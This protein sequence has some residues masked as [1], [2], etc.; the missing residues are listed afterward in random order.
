MHDIIAFVM[1]TSKD[2][3]ARYN[4]E[5][6]QRSTIAVASPNAVP[7]A[8]A[9]AEAARGKAPLMLQR[10]RWT[11]PPLLL[12]SLL[13]LLVC[14]L[15]CCPCC[16]RRRCCRCYRGFSPLLL[17]LRR[18]PRPW[19]LASL[20]PSRL[21]SLW[22]LVVP[23]AHRCCCGCSFLRLLRCF[24][25]RCFFSLL[26]TQSVIA[27]APLALAEAPIAPC[28][29]GPVVSRL[30]RYRRRTVEALPYRDFHGTVCNINEVNN[31]TGLSG[32]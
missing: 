30:P 19:L 13:L 2:V 31:K 23:F 20:L 4:S 26:P 3:V 7:T 27:R 11:K 24:C 32:V 15:R 25:R 9:A 8:A 10:I 5:A 18:P 1:G 28:A 17:L 16:C 29:R 21:P 22:L 14:W 12:M 6:P